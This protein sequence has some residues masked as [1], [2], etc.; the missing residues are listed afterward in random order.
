MNKLILILLTLLLASSTIANDCESPQVTKKSQYDGWRKL[1]N[2]DLVGQLTART[3]FCYNN[4]DYPEKISHVLFDNEDVI[5]F[6]SDEAL[7]A[8]KQMLLHQKDLSIITQ[9]FV[10]NADILN[11]KINSVLEN[12]TSLYTEYSISVYFLRYLGKV[13][14]NKRDRRKINLVLRLSWDNQK[15][16]SYLPYQKKLIKFN[17]LRIVTANKMVSEISLYNNKAEVF[18]LNSSQAERY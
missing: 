3:F 11:L 4:L 16:A 5:R 14:D 10:E 8:K 15:I 9:L 13:E 2:I 6:F 18:K 17:H 12:Q 7:L 1:F